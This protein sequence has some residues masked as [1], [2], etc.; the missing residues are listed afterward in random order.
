MLELDG[1]E[2]KVQTAEECTSDMLDT[3]NDYCVNNDIHNS[4]NEL[5]QIDSTPSSILYM[6]L[7]GL[8]YLVAIL[9]K[10]IYNLG[11]GQS[12]A[13][14][15]EKQLLN[16]ASEC[17]IQRGSASRTTVSVLIY[18]TEVGAC[19]ILVSDTVTLN[20]VSYAPAFD[21]TVPASGVGH[22]ILIAQDEGSFV[23][24]E[25][26]MTGFDSTIENLRTFKQYAR[27]PGREQESVASL[28]ERIQRRTY[29]GTNIDAAEDAIRGLEGVTLCSIYFNDSNSQTITINGIS[30]LPRTAL[31]FVQ[32]YSDKI[33][34]TF[35]QHLS[36][37]TNKASVERTLQQDYVTHSNQVFPVYIIEPKQTACYVQVYISQTVTSVVINEMKD[38]IMALAK[39]LTSGQELTSQMILKSL[40]AYTTYGLEGAMVSADNLSFGY[41]IVPAAD[42]L[43][44]FNS[45]NILITMPELTND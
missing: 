45:D 17:G 5:V 6:I 14:A 11:C 39:E 22:L 2:Y 10:L 19:E 27:I 31:L 33:A 34:E 25:D 4:K 41:K 1:V 40:D 13:N 43:W 7:Y 37:R 24:S 29:S 30:V 44:V 15:S 28:R 8:G 35:Y 32:G 42:E 26:T 21:L 23:V 38:A 36:C 18:A 9:Q 20:N 12:I 16:I 3:I